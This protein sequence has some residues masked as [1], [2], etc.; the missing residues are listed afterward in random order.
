ML[1]LHKNVFQLALGPL[2]RTNKGNKNLMLVS[3]SFTKWEDVIPI[4]LV[5]QVIA[6]LGANFAS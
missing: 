6:I 4:R 3:D 1:V 5:G 2:P